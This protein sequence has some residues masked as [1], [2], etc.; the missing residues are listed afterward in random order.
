VRCFALQ[1]D[2]SERDRSDV[3]GMSTAEVVLAVN[4]GPTAVARTGPRA[5]EG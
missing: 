3:L 2:Q 4:L 5:A 1:Q